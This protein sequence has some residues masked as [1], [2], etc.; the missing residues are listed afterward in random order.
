MERRRACYI[1]G[2]EYDDDALTEHVTSLSR[3]TLV[4]TGNG[5]GAERRVL[6]VAQERGLDVYVPD[7][8]DVR[9]QVVDI[10]VQ[11][12]LGGVLV[13]VGDGFRVRRARAMLDR[14][15]GWPAEVIEL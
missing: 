6:D 8:V 1:G 11:A 10:Y 5:R 13:L 15:N 7:L 3:R 4:V 2:V 9:R 14:S 12:L